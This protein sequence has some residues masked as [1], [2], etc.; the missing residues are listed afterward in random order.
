MVLVGG[1]SEAGADRRIEEVRSGKY[2]SEE[3]TYPMKQETFEKFRAEVEAAEA[4]GKT[5]RESS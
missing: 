5:D 3:H 2:P 4:A 1:V